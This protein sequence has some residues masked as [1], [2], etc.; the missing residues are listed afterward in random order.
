MPA[1]V[2]M[3][4]KREGWASVGVMTSM[5]PHGR[6]AFCTG[7]DLWGPVLGWHRSGSQCF[8]LYRNGQAN[9]TAWCF[10]DCGQWQHNLNIRNTHH[11]LTFRDETVQVGLRHRW[12]VTPPF[13]CRFPTG[14]FAPSGSEGKA[15][16]GRRNILFLS[17][18]W[19]EGLRTPPQHHFPV[20]KW[21]QQPAQELSG[22]HEA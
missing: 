12:G 1:T 19:S 5:Q 22:D 10:V 14:Q 21:L 8:S 11:H 4:G 3:A 15:P 6:P 13:R 9:H 20:K 17:A 7:Q 18:M 2:R 16:F